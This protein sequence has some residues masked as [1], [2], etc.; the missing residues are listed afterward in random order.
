MPKI[1]VLLGMVITMFGGEHGV[2]HVH[3]YW[4]G[5]RGKGASVGVVRISDGALL[6]GKLPAGMLAKVKEWLLANQ[7]MLAAKWKALNPASKSGSPTRGRGRVM[8]RVPHVVSR[9]IFLERL[10]A[11]MVRVTL[12]DGRVFVKRLP[13]PLA[14]TRGMQILFDGH[15]VKLGRFDMGADQMVRGAR[16]VGSY[17]KLAG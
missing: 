9:V 3:V 17:R 12:E 14:A 7:D 15:V 4:S 5:T 1:H 8:K 13:A 6:A 2:P 10:S 11:A 16:Y